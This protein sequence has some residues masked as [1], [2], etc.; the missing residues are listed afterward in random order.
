MTYPLYD[1]LLPTTPTVTVVAV[2]AVIAVAIDQA[3]AGT[4]GTHEHY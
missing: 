1:D 3:N 4:V 2:R